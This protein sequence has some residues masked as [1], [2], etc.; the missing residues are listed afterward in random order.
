MVTT[1]TCTRSYPPS[2]Y[3]NTAQA[4]MIGIERTQC[5]LLNQGSLVRHFHMFGLWPEVSDMSHTIKASAIFESV[6]TI[7]SQLTTIQCRDLYTPTA[8]YHGAYGGLFNHH[9]AMNFINLHY[10]CDS[11]RTLSYK[12]SWIMVHFE[13]Y[14][15]KQLKDEMRKNAGK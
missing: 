12:I 10:D 6:W 7:A 11:G 4:R 2:F 8:I 9:G 13:E 15:T 1:N 14:V 3:S 5:T